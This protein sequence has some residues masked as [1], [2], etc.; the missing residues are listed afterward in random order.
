[1]AADPNRRVWLDQNFALIPRKPFRF[2]D[3]GHK[4]LKRSSL[5]SALK[6]AYRFRGKSLT[7]EL[8]IFRDGPDFFLQIYP[9]MERWPYAYSKHEME[10]SRKQWMQAKPVCF[11]VINPQ[12]VEK[13]AEYLQKAGAK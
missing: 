4:L 5:Y 11:K 8:Y 3:T 6:K 7:A 10:E 12:L 13:I 1:M 2:L 9:F